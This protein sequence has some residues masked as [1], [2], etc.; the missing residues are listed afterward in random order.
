MSL[1]KQPQSHVGA[2]LA[3]NV[4]WFQ[5]S[6][7]WIAAGLRQKIMAQCHSR[8]I[9]VMSRAPG[10]EY[11]KWPRTPRYF[12]G[13]PR[14]YS[15]AVKLGVIDH[16]VRGLVASLNVPG[17]VSTFASCSGHL[18]PSYPLWSSNKLPYVAF[19]AAPELAGKLAG[20]LLRDSLDPSGQL[21]YLWTVTG[22]FDESDQISFA[23]RCTAARWQTRSRLNEDMRLLGLWVDELFQA[24]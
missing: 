14:E 15:E 22:H 4:H 17:I 24:L 7:R 2:Q 12:K 8:W 10:S 11:V 9:V 1:R 21:H 13:V 20:R 18:F 6:T 23:L 5:R 19:R 16:R 3:R